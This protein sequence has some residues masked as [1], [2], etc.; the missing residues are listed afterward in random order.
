MGY[1]IPYEIM[2][3]GVGVHLS[4]LLLRRLAGHQFVAGK[5]TLVHH[6]LYA[7]I[8]ICIIIIIILL[9][10]LVNHSILSHN[11]LAGSK[12]PLY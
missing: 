6:L 8:W 11:N 5:Q 7:F 3:K 12:Y 9:S 1:S 2:M 10:I 4:L